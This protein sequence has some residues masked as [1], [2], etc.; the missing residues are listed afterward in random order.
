MEEGASDPG[1]RRV[2]HRRVME[3]KVAYEMSCYSQGLFF[4][5]IFFWWASFQSRYKR[6][7]LCGI[8]QS[9]FGK[10]EIHV[11]RSD[12]FQGMFLEASTI[13]FAVLFLQ[14]HHGVR[15]SL[16]KRAK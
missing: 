14:Y 1:E 5:G 3:P 2:C 15:S 4:F 6:L 13:E 16:E 8:C 10:R 12:R 11:S 9:A 7:Q